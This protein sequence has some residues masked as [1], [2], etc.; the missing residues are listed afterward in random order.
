M[1]AAVQRSLWIGTAVHE[2]L[3]GFLPRRLELVR[4]GEHG[5]WVLERSADGDTASILTQAMTRDGDL[6]RGLS[7]VDARAGAGIDLSRATPA[8]ARP[9]RSCF[10]TS[11]DLREWMV[12]PM[13]TR[14]LAVEDHHLVMT[15]PEP[16]A[17]IAGLAW[18]VAS[19]E[20]QTRMEEVWGFETRLEACLV[21]ATSSSSER[22]V[23]R[24][25]LLPMASVSMTSVVLTN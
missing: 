6:I 15:Q 10:A 7:R 12:E 24:K 23:R 21:L 14:T 22:L 19:S 1:S 5:F 18:C 2:E 4:Y 9:L 17:A 8:Q 20:Q 25:P 16:S 13:W 3:A 11:T